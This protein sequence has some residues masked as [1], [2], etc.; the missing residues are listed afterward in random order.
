MDYSVCNIGFIQTEIF[1]SDVFQASY[2]CLPVFRL[3]SRHLMHIEFVYIPCNDYENLCTRTLCRDRE[4]NRVSMIC[5]QR[6]G[7]PSCG[8]CKSLT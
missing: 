7:F 3:R 6:R 2:L 4:S 1:I 5:S 8:R